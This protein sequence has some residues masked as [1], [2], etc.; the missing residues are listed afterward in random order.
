MSSSSAGISVISTCSRW[1]HVYLIA[2]YIIRI[3]VLWSVMLYMYT[4]IQLFISYFS[5]LCLSL[6]LSFPFFPFLLFS[7]YFF[8]PKQKSLDVSYIT[9]RILVMS[10]PY[11]EGGPGH[12]N[13]LREI[14]AYLEGI[15]PFQ[16]LIFNIFGEQYSINQLCIQVGGG[17]ILVV[18]NLY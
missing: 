7:S 2:Y 18:I 9:S 11:E 5:F 13:V 8:S 6:L 4:C 3:T 1:K 16:Y 12:P 14:S 10:Y 15:H 17:L